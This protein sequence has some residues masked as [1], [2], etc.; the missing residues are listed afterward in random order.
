MTIDRMK[1]SRRRKWI[2]GSAGV[3]FVLVLPAIVFFTESNPTPTRAA[4]AG[5]SG[6]WHGTMTPRRAPDEPASDGSV[7]VDAVLHQDGND[8]KE[9]LHNRSL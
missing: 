2:V 9:G 3:F 4:V 8:V 7:Q 6:N 5:V 1:V